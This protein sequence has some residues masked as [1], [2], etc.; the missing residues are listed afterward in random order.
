MA[1]SIDTP[2]PSQSTATA[3][4][5]DAGRRPV[6]APAVDRPAAPP[7]ETG[8]AGGGAPDPVLAVVQHLAGI[9]GRPAT[10][11]LIVAGLPLENGRLT[12]ALLE[13]SLQRVGLSTLRIRKSFAQLADFELPAVF[14]TLEGRLSVVLGREARGRVKCFDA[15][16]GQIRTLDHTT[17]NMGVRRDFLVVQPVYGANEDQG[18]PDAASQKSWLGAAL[19]G[20]WRSVF[21]ILLAAVFINVF[22]IAFPI[23]SLNVYDRVLPNSATATLWILSIG[24]LIVLVF[25]TVLKL[26]RG[27]IIDYVGRRIDHRLSSA[28][29]DR[30]LNTS[31][32][33]RPPSTGAFINRISQ[34]EVLRDFLASSTLVMFVDVLF[35]GVFA[36]VIAVLVGW[37]VVFPLIAGVVA[38]VVT[39]TIGLRSG[40]SVQAALA[41]SS[42]RNSILVETLSAPQT[43]KASRAE[44]EFLRRWEQTI[45]ASSETHNR[46]KWYQS[47]A[48][49]VTAVTSQISMV[50]IIIGGT[51]LFAEGQISMGAIIAAMMLS[52]RLI[53]P[54][55]QISGLLLKTRGASEAFKAVKAIMELPDERDNGG[56]FVTRAIS[57]GKVEFR[58]VR[59][60]YPGAKQFV[61]DGVNFTVN[62]GEKVG[63]IG[64]IG[65]GKTTI[66]RL[67]VNFY[68]PVEG[69]ILIDGVAIDQ[70]HPH[71]LRRQIG[72]VVQDPELFNGTVRENILLSN[73]T[74]SDAELIEVSKRAGV[75][76][77][78]SRHPL[79]FDLPV[80]ERGA[81]L[82]GG[83]RQAIAL[84]RTMLTKPT[85]L[86]LDE[87]S[88][89][90]DLATER[91]LIQH[92]S[93]S[94]APEHTVLIATHRFSLLALVTR[95]LVIENGRI[96]ADG[97]REAVLAQLKTRGDPT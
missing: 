21:F 1:R 66:G 80:G 85:I 13:P 44:G 69:E 93:A 11:D 97:A 59:F 70:Y 28:L 43:V 19:S 60:A 8:A 37:L 24:L 35:M 42:A 64:R 88:S 40:K 12:E 91:Q 52:N 71:E 92:L 49:N 86:F 16:T 26:A 67:M 34:Y 10:R 75:D 2:T 47:L 31:L 4:G 17:I 72:L 78:V 56:R 83:Q 46:I 7:P 38:I 76:D 9:W 23:F 82:S 95:L 15:A 33:S 68:Q 51:Y 65:S 14:V 94:L 79:G 3:E 89:S 50:A 32:G 27:A 84:A 55:A 39:L 87:P 22:A 81:L 77:F 90:M 62:A 53:A 29:F 41:E 20:H 5:P 25:D 30:V 57:G 58:K 18:R 54:I 48:T 63:I 36:Y 74:A 45:A 73:P 6:P 96:V 61:I